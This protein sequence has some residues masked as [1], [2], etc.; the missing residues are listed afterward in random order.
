MNLE[1]A[2]RTSLWITAP[3]N[4][5]AACAFAFPSSVLGTTLQLPDAHPFYSA[6]SASFVGIFG[7]AYVW[8]AQ[9]PDISRPV[10]CLGACGKMLA[11]LISVALFIAGDLSGVAASIIS[12]DLVFVALWSVFLLKAQ[13][14]VDA[15]C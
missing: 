7:L 8:L 13:D 6:L 9:Q 3:A 15:S 12:L 2:V 1:I 5:L 11:A 14:S 4:L 10:L